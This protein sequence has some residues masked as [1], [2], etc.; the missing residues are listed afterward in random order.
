M[1]WIMEL[2][3][4]HLSGC[5][6]APLGLET[7]GHQAPD[8]AAETEKK[9]LKP[10]CNSALVRQRLHKPCRSSLSSSFDDD[11]RSK[12]QEISTSSFDHRERI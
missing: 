2:L 12:I 11:D 6:P 5:V 7:D 4:Y 10:I 9:G 1:A 3:V 8:Q